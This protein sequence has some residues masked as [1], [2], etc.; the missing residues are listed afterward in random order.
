MGNANVNRMGGYGVASSLSD[1]ILDMVNG[2]SQ[3]AAGGSRSRQRKRMPSSTSSKRPKPWESFERHHEWRDQEDA[4]ATD[5]QKFIFDIM[6]A[7]TKVAKDSTWWSLVKRIAEGDSGEQAG[8]GS[9]G[10][11]R[12]KQSQKTRSNAGNSH[13]R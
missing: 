8:G 2:K 4:G 3:H 9:G 5:A 12:R 1:F 10:K 13:S 7:A 11:D 6:S